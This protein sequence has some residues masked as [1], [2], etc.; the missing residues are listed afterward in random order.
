MH[1]VYQAS[2]RIAMVRTKE[3]E[4]RQQ[5]L[6]LMKVKQHIYALANKLVTVRFAM[7]RIVSN[8]FRLKDE[9]K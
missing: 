5:Y 4:C 3:A 7:G 8:A 2:N 9:E 6:Q 1:V